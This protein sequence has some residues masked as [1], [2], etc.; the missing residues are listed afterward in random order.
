MNVYMKQ[1]GRFNTIIHK[2]GRWLSF[3][4]NVFLHNFRN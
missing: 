3:D 4:H 2:M 1:N